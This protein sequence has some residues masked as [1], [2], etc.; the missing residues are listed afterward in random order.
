MMVQRSDVSRLGKAGEE[1]ECSQQAVQIGQGGGRQS[2]G[3]PAPN[4]LI[5]DRERETHTP[6]R[7][8]TL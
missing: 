2:T 7:E 4:S 8:G 3:P 6:R 5:H 1:G